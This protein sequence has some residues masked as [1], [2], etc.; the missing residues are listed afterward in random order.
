MGMSSGH[1]LVFD[2]P[3]LQRI[4]TVRIFDNSAITQITFDP[5]NFI[6]VSSADGALQALSC[7]EKKL[8]Y[9][10]LDLGHERFCTVTLPRSARTP[11]LGENQDEEGGGVCSRNQENGMFCCV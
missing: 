7:I 10:Y 4:E 1:L 6:F 2:Y 11:V 9:I 3:T 8:D 5:T